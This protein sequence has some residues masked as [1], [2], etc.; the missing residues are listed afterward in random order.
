MTA[1]LTTVKKGQVL[2]IYKG[3]GG[4]T[5]ARS[6][7]CDM[8]SNKVHIKGLNDVNQKVSNVMTQT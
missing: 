2:S 7:K 6:N 5:V 1:I 4:I 8:V 3:G